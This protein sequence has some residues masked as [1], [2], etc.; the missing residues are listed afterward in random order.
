MVTTG[1]V[2]RSAGFKWVL[3]NP[4]KILL[5][6][7]FFREG[8]KGL[9]EQP[10]GSL[11]IGCERITETFITIKSSRREVI[12]ISENFKLTAIMSIIFKLKASN[13]AFYMEWN[14]TLFPITCTKNK[15]GNVGWCNVFTDF[16]HSF[17]QII[18]NRVYMETF[19]FWHTFI[20]YR[21]L[22]SSNIRN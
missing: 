8:I 1:C 19:T 11:L 4:C 2:Q 7:K 21:S 15:Y 18:H 3:I 5:N 20:Y 16:F 13:E 22:F 12:T 10:S 14:S 9:L 17:H 6:V